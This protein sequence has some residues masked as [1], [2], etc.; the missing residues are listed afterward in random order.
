MVQGE[1]RQTGR[2]RREEKEGVKRS[3]TEK[4][5][6]TRMEMVVERSRQE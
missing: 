3:K 1:G 5:V 2:R 6:V 4:K